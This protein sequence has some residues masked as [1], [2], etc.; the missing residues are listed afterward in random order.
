[1]AAGNQG[2]WINAVSAVSTTVAATL[3]LGFLG[4][5]KD[6]AAQQPL[7]ASHMQTTSEKLA[8]IEGRQGET[9]LVLAGMV[10]DYTPRDVLRAE[11]DKVEAKIRDLQVQ[12]ALLRQ[13]IESPRRS[14]R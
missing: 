4:T 14:T 1:M 2:A 11:I 9:S 7:I 6:M 5:V 13:A 8:T 12:Q 10:K 3:L